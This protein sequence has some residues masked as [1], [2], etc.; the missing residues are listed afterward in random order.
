MA[1]IL[2]F[3]LTFRAGAE[4]FSWSWEKDKKNTAPSEKIQPGNTG[5]AP[6]AVKASPAPGSDDNFFWSWEKDAT[7]AGAAKSSKSGDAK[8]GKEARS[9]GSNLTAE[10]E[11]L[12]GA[13]PKTVVLSDPS[14]QKN[15]GENQ[16]Q[17]VIH[18]VQPAGPKP[19]PRR[20]NPPSSPIVAPTVQVQPVQPEESG[21]Q[22]VVPMVA[23]VPDKKKADNLKHSF[24][25]KA[26]D[27][28]IKE[29]LDLHKKIAE[30]KQDK[31]MIRIENQRL[32]REIKDM[33]Q[34]IADSI[35]KIKDLSRQKESLSNSSAEIKSMEDRLKKAEQEKV[36]L[37]G[38][39]A[40]LQKKSLDQGKSQPAKAV[41]QPAVKPVVPVQVGSDL[42]KKLEGENMLLK[43]KLTELD[44][45]RQK[46]VKA[47][48]EFEKKEKL[49]SEESRRAVEAQKNMKEKLD[50]ARSVEKKQK[51]MMIDL[52]ER[53]PD[54]EKEAAELRQKLL[55]KDEALKEKER[56][57]EVLANEIHQ[58][59]NRIR[60]A[61]KMVELMDQA[62]KDVSQVSDGEKR[63]M[64]YNMA[65]VYSQVGRYRDAEREYLHALRLDPTD[66]DVH[67]NLGILYD[68]N[69]NDKTRAAMH[70]RRYLKLR[71]SGPDVDSVKNWLMNIDMKQ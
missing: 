22:A 51:K 34:R 5:G 3:V 57:L 58:R 50:D 29:N 1:V 33:E 69:L 45:E 66:A 16:Q 13:V 56:N 4:D 39:L 31:D 53:I 6:E 67:Y 37:S 52:A 68:E 43:Q 49:A 36:S 24:D 47:R 64:H 20:P 55:E 21:N 54:M 62:Q 70:Y 15:A 65:A 26:Y 38:Q 19:L 10:I 40:A 46:A 42:Y 35:V 25:S 48:E 23:A 71:P 17:Q 32:A 30:A 8:S 41:G 44:A 28:L 7:A 63:D 9:Q 60:K 18:P 59:E 2:L 27:E 11:N 12:S 14:A 61:E